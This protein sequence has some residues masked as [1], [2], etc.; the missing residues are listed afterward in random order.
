VYTHREEISLV[1]ACKQ[2]WQNMRAYQTITN[3]LCPHIN[4]ELLLVSM[5]YSVSYNSYIKCLR[6]HVDMDIISCFGM[7]NSWPKF[8]H[9]LQ[10]HPVYSNNH[11]SRACYVLHVGTVSIICRHV[12]AVIVTIH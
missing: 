8:V 4:A 6:T 7:W 12:T 1:G 9:I 10:L 5:Q 2:M 3:N 11:Y